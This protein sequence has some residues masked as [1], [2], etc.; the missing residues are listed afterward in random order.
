MFAVS[1]L[2]SA[3]LAAQD[4]A[5]APQGDPAP[6]SSTGSSPDAARQR[7]RAE[8]ERVRASFQELYGD[9]DAA[10]L[11]EL[12]RAHP[13]LVLVT[14]DADLEESLAVW[15]EA[16]TQPDQRRIR[17]LEERARWGA[18]IASD[19]TGQPIFTDYAASFTGWNPDQKVEFRAGQAAHGRA[20][21]ALQEGDA[22]AALVAAV[23]C[24]ELALPLGDWWGAAMGYAAEGRALLAVGHPARALAATSQARLLYHQ[25][26][27]RRNEH[28]ELVA[29]LDALERL[30]RWSRARATANAAL[31]L[32]RSFAERPG[33]RGLLERRAAIERRMGLSG[34]ADDTERELRALGG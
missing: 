25:L 4:P 7:A 32:A 2:A 13:D 30:E 34:A 20:A 31:E 11:R 14:I 28:A 21:S 23:E 33:V 22:E 1:I 29:M 26:G 3:L 18:W 24:R 5:P 10:G 17:L 6:G 15:E 19:V 9:Q 27:L 16:P 12:W 8:R